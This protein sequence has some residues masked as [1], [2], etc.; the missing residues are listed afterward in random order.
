MSCAGGVSNLCNRSSPPGVVVRPQWQ[1]ITNS[2][3]QTV[4]GTLVIA[5][6][7][8]LR[9]TVDAEAHAVAAILHDL[10]WDQTPNSAVVSA[11]R[12]FE[13]DGA[14]AARDFIRTH[15]R[16]QSAWDDHRVQ[17]VW[18]SIALHTQD[19]I[20][21][22]KQDNVA[23]TGTGILMDFTGPSAGV[24]Q[25]EYDT[26]I[27]AFPKTQFDQGVNETFIWLCGT[28]SA[29]TYDTFMQPWGDNY[30]ANYSAKGH[31]IFD[32][33]FTYTETEEV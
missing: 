22:Y 23:V 17:L 31:R 11:D 5:H 6:N 4:Y 2:I 10:G 30:I 21:K 16:D 7:D 14:I 9:A 32:T 28:K 15:S 27:A 29:T 3:H 1:V 12:R 33:L 26:V 20:F 24:T 25:Q 13:V 8:T 19:S 18:D